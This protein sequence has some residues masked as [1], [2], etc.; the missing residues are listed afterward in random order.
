LISYV[1]NKPAT[2]AQ[3]STTSQPASSRGRRGSRT[4]EP[5]P[6][7]KKETKSKVKYD[8]IKLE[9]FSSSGELIRT[10]TQKA[11]EENG[12]HRMTW[13]M[14]EKGVQR[15]SREER[16]GGG[17]RFNFEPSGVDVLPGT[18]K[19]R[20]GFGDQKDSTSINVKYDPRYDVP[21]DVIKARYDM[22][23][24]L[25]KLTSIAEDAASRLRESKK[26]VEDF[27]KDLK[28]S[29][30]TD[31]KEAKDKTKAMKDSIEA[32]LDYMFGKEDERQGITRSPDPTPLTYIYIAS[33][34]VGS[35]RD[36]ISDTDRRV[37]KHADDKITEM[38]KKV[39]EFFTT[40]W[41]A[42]RSTMEKVTLSPFK[43]FEPLKKE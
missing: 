8:S 27:E 28:E 18:Y 23:K 33:S 15:P 31:L 6:E 3:P 36:P 12:V 40:Q 43:D 41:S 20:I 29:K 17:G 11:P 13:N 24:D 16:R 22:Q 19:L 21:A 35:S 26:I 37:Y 1:I 25:E 39:N 42:Y 4:P 34:Y 32:V 38:V 10:L 30:R 2:S 9:I 7:E 14:T 5:K